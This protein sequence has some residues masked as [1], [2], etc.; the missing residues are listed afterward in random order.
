M[1]EGE[2]NNWIVLTDESKDVPGNQNT[3][4][5]Q[6]S[7]Q[8]LFFRSPYLQEEPDSQKRIICVNLHEHSLN[9][10]FL[11]Q[12][13]K[14]NCKFDS[15]L[16][17][18]VQEN[19]GKTISIQVTYFYTVQ[20]LYNNTMR[21]KG[22][23][24]PPVWLECCWSPFSPLLSWRETWEILEEYSY[25]EERFGKEKG[26]RFQRGKNSRSFSTTS[27]PSLGLLDLLAFP[28]I[29]IWKINAY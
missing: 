7:T 1:K 24:Y 5:W 21:R 13:D 8:D 2:K 11:L 16:R 29:P 27:L 23:T 20:T 6:T 15:E 17:T 22:K 18:K 19:T 25:S 10:L 28:F 12:I 14:H 4:L 9:E 3:V 26:R